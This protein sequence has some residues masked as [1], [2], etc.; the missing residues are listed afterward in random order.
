MILQEL[1]WYEKNLIIALR[2]IM[3]FAR[4]YNLY[5]VS[6][7]INSRDGD[8]LILNSNKSKYKFTFIWNPGIDILIEKKRLIEGH[9][10][11]K[12]IISLSQ[13]KKEYP[14]FSFLS[15]NFKNAKEELELFDGYIKFLESCFS[16]FL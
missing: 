2:S 5:I 7:D 9:R 8:Y 4:K 13:V 11:I 15:D 6:M 16:K 3:P 14:N 12:K 1:E 10:N